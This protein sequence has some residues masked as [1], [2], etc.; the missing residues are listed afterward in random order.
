MTGRILSDTYLFADTLQYIRSGHELRDDE[1]TYIDPPRNSPIDWTAEIYRRPMR[2]I[3]ERLD[4]IERFLSMEPLAAFYLGEDARLTFRKLRTAST[5][6]RTSATKLCDLHEHGYDIRAAENFGIRSIIQYKA[7]VWAAY[8][9][10][11]DLD[12]VGDTLEEA[13]A[14]IETLSRA[15]LSA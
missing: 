5:W 6:L 7:D 9:R 12:R 13:V 1:N 15:V 2:R 8:A 4:F 11:R 3:R 14:G 10:A